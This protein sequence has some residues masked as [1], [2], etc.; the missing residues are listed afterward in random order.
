VIASSSDVYITGDIKY[1][2]AQRA[3]EAGLAL[4]DVGHFASERVV[5]DSLAVYLRSQVARNE[6][7]VEVRVASHEKDPFW[8]V[9]EEVSNSVGE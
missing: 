6:F 7:S 8:S 4:I 1:H 3:T 2:E 5:L 9:R